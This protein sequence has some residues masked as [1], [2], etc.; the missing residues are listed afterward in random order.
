M[1]IT[2]KE[3]VLAFL[4]DAKKNSGK[5]LSVSD[6]IKKHGLRARLG[7]ALKKS[8]LIAVTSTGYTWESTV[9]PNVKMAERLIEDARKA[10]SEA[11]AKYVAKK[12]AE[13]VAVCETAEII[14][15]EVKPL[16]SQ[17]KVLIEAAE[18]DKVNEAKE[19]IKPIEE[20]KVVEEEVKTKGFFRWLRSLFGIKN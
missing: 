17:E 20:V 1:A 5:S 11:N 19:T 4:K 13:K 15:A 14:N 16:T 7:T 3:T 9:L 10:K 8:K 2:N 18:I 6:L 12:K